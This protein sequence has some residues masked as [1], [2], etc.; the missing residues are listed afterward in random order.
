MDILY[1]PPI[2]LTV[3]TPVVPVVGEYTT[4]IFNRSNGGRSTSIRIA[5]WERDLINKATAV[6][7]MDNFSLFV[8]W[9][10]IQC[11]EEI[12]ADYKNWEEQNATR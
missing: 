10:A 1:K 11:A 6:I 9:C 2:R 3:P 12:L 8:R 5:K 4:G 7:G